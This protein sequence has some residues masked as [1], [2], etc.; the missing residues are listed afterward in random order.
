M[1]LFWRD[2]LSE[3]LA[4]APHLHRDILISVSNS[5]DIYSLQ[6]VKN[7]SAIIAEKWIFLKEHPEN[8]TWWLNNHV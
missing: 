3:G 6:M 7:E 2:D 5:K 4:K 1:H 8:Q